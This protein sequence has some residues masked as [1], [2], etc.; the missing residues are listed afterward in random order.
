MRIMMIANDT[1]FAWNL[2]REI[3]QAFILAGHRVVLVAQI[4]DFRKNFEEIGI[5]II[6]AHT[7]RHGTNPIEDLKL[8]LFYKKIIRQ[9]SPDIVF[10][11]NIK[12]NVY[13]G[14]ACQVLKIPYIPN[15][16]GL[17]TP[18]ENPGKLQRLTINLYKTGVKKAKTIFFQNQENID[19]FS[20]HNMMPE[21]AKIVLLPGSG[22]N[23]KTHSSLDWPDSETQIHFLYAA[24]IM[25]E[26]GIELLLAAAH[27]YASN[28]V[29]FDI[30]GKC[31]DA[32]YDK[33]LKND[34]C[35]V[36]HGFQKDMTPFYAQCSCFLYP[37]YYPEGMSNVLLEAAAHCRP[38]IAT[39]RAGCRE[40]V[41]D[42]KSGFIIPIKNKSALFEAVEKF[43][44]M[45][46]E[47][48]RDMGLAGRAKI[49][50]EFDRKIVIKAYIEEIGEK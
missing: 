31:D 41:D 32:Q 2:R 11:N 7:E 46:W 35:V 47:Q 15:I 16:T 33:I 18:V 28:K 19:F 49:E 13:A 34:K 44:G 48:R 25:K 50:R 4:L 21:K 37:S 5:R 42:G 1:N 8:F 39:N 36:Y 17:G 6:D 27:K 26:K 24:R 14:F 29:V 12:P 3:L 45:T 40:T 22:V 9:E 43:L 10:T 20:S 30:C 23:L 38:I